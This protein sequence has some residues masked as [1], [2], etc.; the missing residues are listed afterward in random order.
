MSGGTTAQKVPAWGG[1]MRRSPKVRTLQN[2]SRWLMSQKW[3]FRFPV[4]LSVL[5]ISL[6]FLRTDAKSNSTNQRHELKN[7][8]VRLPCK[9]VHCSDRLERSSPRTTRRSE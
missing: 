8:Q 3:S 5:F 2:I 4:S 7:T 6:F 1:R 9:I